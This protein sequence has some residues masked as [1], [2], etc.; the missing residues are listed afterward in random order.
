MQKLN[1][2]ATKIFCRLLKKLEGKNYLKIVIPEYMP[3]VIEQLQQD[4]KTPVGEG[5]LYSLCHYFELNGDLMRDPEMCFIMVDNRTEPKDYIA[6]GIYPQLYRLDSLGLYEEC[7]R[8]EYA[9]VTNCITAWQKGHCSFA[10]TWLKNI[11]QQGF[12]N[13]ARQ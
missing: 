2:S 12:L 8:I 11:A 10:N 7:I 5:R 4:I 1:Q 3:L 6:V 13:A 9:K